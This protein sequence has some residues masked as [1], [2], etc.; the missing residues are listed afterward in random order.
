MEPG[1]R[2]LLAG[3]HTA[4]TSQQ[5]GDPPRH[6][7]PFESVNRSWA[8]LVLNRNSLHRRN[9]WASS[10]PGPCFLIPF[11]SRGTHTEKLARL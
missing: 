2:V 8:A 1:T 5:K 3:H 11:Q 4:A 7:V 9:Y 6:S 10:S